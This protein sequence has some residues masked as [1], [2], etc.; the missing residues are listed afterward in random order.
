MSTMPL[1]TYE[2]S[3]H[4]LCRNGTSF[5]ASNRSVVNVR[6]GRLTIPVDHFALPGVGRLYTNRGAIKRQIGRRARFGHLGDV[7]EVVKTAHEGGLIWG[8]SGYATPGPEYLREGRVMRMIFT[9]LHQWYQLPSLVVDGGVSDGVPGLS[10][11]IAPHYTVPTLGYVPLKGLDSYGPRTH[12]VAHKQTYREREVMVGVTPDIL[13]CV[14]GAGGTIRECEA[15]LRNGGVVLMLAPKNDYD[16]QSLPG[17]YKNNP[18]IQQHSKNFFTCT[19]GQ[20]VQEHL[21]KV[22]YRARH[23]SLPSRHARLKKLSAELA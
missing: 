2:D 11:V 13:V 10:G 16:E 21:P 18:V 8:F 23:I 15:A 19:A 7:A 5:P 1:P 9:A 3:Y 22:I 6:D 20:L 4:S 17:T 14:G 12:L